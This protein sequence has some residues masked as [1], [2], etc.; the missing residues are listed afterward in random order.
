MKANEMHYFSNLF[1][2]RTLHVLDRSVVHHQ[3]SHTVYT[4][5]GIC[6]ASYVDCLLVGS[7]W[8]S[9]P[10]SLAGSQHN[11]LTYLISPWSRVLIEKLTVSAASQEIPCILWNLKVHYRQS[12]LLAD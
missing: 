8:S 3:E 4:A 11:L 5:I 2:Q 9:I 6:H 1:W 10:T 12:L 7:G